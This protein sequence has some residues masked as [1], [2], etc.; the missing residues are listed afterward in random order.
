MSGTAK[1]GVRCRGLVAEGAHWQ[2]QPPS[3]EYT[4]KKSFRTGRGSVGPLRARGKRPIRI[5]TLGESQRGGGK[6]GKGKKRTPENYLLGR[7]TITERRKK[8]E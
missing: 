4:P 3:T 5:L 7:A 2:T 1:A 6:G 8:T